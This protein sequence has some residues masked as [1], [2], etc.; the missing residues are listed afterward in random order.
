MTTFSDLTNEKKENNISLKEKYSLLKKFKPIWL[1]DIKNEETRN[2]IVEAI[3]ILPC[4]F[5]VLWEGEKTKKVAYTK[6]LWDDFISWFDFVVSCKEGQDVLDFMKK[7]IVPIIS[8]ENYIT[9]SLQE[10]EPLKSVWN[11]FL[12]EKDEVYD[13]FYA[14]IRYLENYK[15][16]YDNKNL[17]KNTSK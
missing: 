1:I 17:V 4:D 10:F 9:V 12:F 2:K 7:W 13:I 5:I 16:P 15:F 6:D 14:L 3:E 11:C 8:Q